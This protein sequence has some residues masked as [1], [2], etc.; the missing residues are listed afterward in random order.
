MK[1]A[2]LDDEKYFVE[3]ILKRIK[4]F[5]INDVIPNVF[6]GFT[7]P[8]KFLESFTIE[9]YDLVFIDVEMEDKNGLEVAKEV[10]KI[11]PNCII[12]FVSAFDYK[13]D[14]YK[15]QAFQYIDK[16]IDEVLFID[17]LDRAVRKYKR[18]N[19]NIII[20]TF[21]GNKC[22]FTRDILYLQTNYRE[23]YLYTIDK[24]INGSS[25]CITKAKKDLLNYHFFQ[26]NRSIII[27]LGQVDTFT[28][29]WV[30]MNNG[31]TLTITKR[32]RKEFKIRYME[33]TDLEAT[34]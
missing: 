4:R 1:I 12:T 26:I 29:E 21:S 14:S 9:E 25:K 7:D 6:N 30:R 27:N 24:I 18:L 3:D 17:E 22:V 13:H 5:E 23:Y 19:Q 11:K 34:K 16:P 33:Y 31:E 2:V 32:K 8:I 15:V 10:R 20:N 28:S